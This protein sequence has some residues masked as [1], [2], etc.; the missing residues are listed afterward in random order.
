MN[1]ESYCSAVSQ[2]CWSVQ[3]RRKIEA[4][5]SLPADSPEFEE[6]TEY[7][8]IGEVTREELRKMNEQNEKREKRRHIKLWIILSAAVLLAAGGGIA[9]GV[10]MR[11]KDTTVQKNDPNGDLDKGLGLH[12]TDQCFNQAEHIRNDQYLR[13]SGWNINYMPCARSEYGWYHWNSEKIN[14]EIVQD[15]DESYQSFDMKYYLAFTDKESGQTVPLCARPN[16]EHDGSLYCTATTKAYN[17]SLPVNYDGRLIATALRNSDPDNYENNKQSFVLIEYEPDGTAINELC[18]VSEDVGGLINFTEPFI[19]RGYAWMIVPEIRSSERDPLTG[20]ITQNGGWKIYGYE[21]ATGKTVC[22]YSTMPEPD[23]A[24]VYTMP[25]K[26]VPDGDYLYFYI[27]EQDTYSSATAKNDLPVGLY[28][29]SLLSGQTE[30][31][32]DGWNDNNYTVSGNYVIGIEGSSIVR[33]YNM[34]TK[35][36]IMLE[37]CACAYLTDGEYIYMSRY[38]MNER[39]QEAIQ[40]Y[41]LSGKLIREIPMKEDGFSTVTDM[42]IADGNM[43]IYRCGEVTLEKNKEGVEIITHEMP[44]VLYS[45]I[46][47]VKAGKPEWKLAYEVPGEEMNNPIPEDEK[48]KESDSDA[49]KNAESD[50]ENAEGS[51]DSDAQ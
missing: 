7:T 18:T 5:L 43:Y 48:F 9:A 27:P 15:G 13:N 42:I 29:L 34:E 37:N 51:D 32:F 17:A 31:V 16:C 23:K 4:L 19:H 49:A 11:Q 20:R 47:A 24:E 33:V 22:V 50:D 6:E 46:E 39:I 30:K 38:G 41:D 40:I 44:M 2:I 26:L 28:R 35:E 36:D 25:I 21:F 3:Q 1:K 10:A 14:F 45:D 8:V 12:L